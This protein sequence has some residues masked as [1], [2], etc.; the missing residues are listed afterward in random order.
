MDIYILVFF[1]TVPHRV[2]IL[3]GF[4]HTV[5]ASENPRGFAHTV[6][7]SRKPKDSAHKVGA[8]ENCRGIAHTEGASLE[9]FAKPLGVQ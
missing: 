8:S 2:P 4:A 9:T 3:S 5:Q 7:A 1:P 6:G